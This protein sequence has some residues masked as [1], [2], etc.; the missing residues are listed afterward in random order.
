MAEPAPV[1]ALPDRAADGSPQD[2]IAAG[3]PPTESPWGNITGNEPASVAAHR[4][5]V[6]FGD[7]FPIAVGV[8]VF[9]L[10]LAWLFWPVV[11]TALA[12]L[13]MRC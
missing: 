7:W 4:R 1:E 9:A 8:T 6:Q 5:R 2:A 10:I 12:G 13:V 3:P 11:E